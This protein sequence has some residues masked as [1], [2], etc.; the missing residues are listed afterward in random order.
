LIGFCA[1][2]ECNFFLNPDRI[3]TLPSGGR[4][5]QSNKLSNND[6][7]LTIGRWRD[8]PV[9]IVDFGQS[10]SRA[11]VIGIRPASF[12]SARDYGQAGSGVSVMNR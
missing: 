12:V 8:Q 4:I 7:M 11:D 1:T 5:P 10:R 3:A 6:L 2:L 9:G